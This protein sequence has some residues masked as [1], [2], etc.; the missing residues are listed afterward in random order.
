MLTGQK[1]GDSQA[2]VSAPIHA[3]ISGKVIAIKSVTCPT[4]RSSLAV[5]IESDGNDTWVDTNGSTLDNLSLTDIK[6]LVREAGL[7]GMGGAMFPT[8]VKVS[9]PPGKSFD[10]VILNGAECEPYL[11]C[12]QRL[13]MEQADMLIL[14]LKA[15]LKVTGA[16]K[17]Y[18]GIEDNKK[19][20]IATL[21]RAVAGKE[22]LKLYRL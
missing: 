8:H 15:W 21:K 6:S 18:I 22:T 20:A 12:D 10:A 16:P 17:G 5:V 1:I 19:E 4:G 11:T 2:F 3:N 9:P 13:M 7:V 14:G